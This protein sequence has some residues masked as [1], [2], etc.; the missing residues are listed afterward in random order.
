ML[1]NG[2]NTTPPLAETGLEQMNVSGEE[3]SASYPSVEPNTIESCGLTPITPVPVTAN[4]QPSPEI[5]LKFVRNAFPSGRVTLTAILSDE[6]NR[7]PEWQNKKGKTVTRTLCSEEEIISWLNRAP[8]HKLNLYFTANALAGEHRKKPEKTDIKAARFLYCD[9]DPRAG[10]DLEA[11][12]S[13]ILT[14]IRN[15][16]LPPTVVIF[17]GGGY[18]CLWLLQPEV[19]INTPEDILAVEN[20]N[21]W[22]GAKFLAAD[23]TQNI[24]RLLRLPGSVNYPD[25]GKQKKGRQAALAYVVEELTDWSRTYRLEDFLEETPPKPSIKSRIAQV[26]TLPD[27]VSL[28][29]AALESLAELEKWGISDALRDLI[30]TG[31]A[32]HHPSRSETLYAAVCGLARCGVPDA[33]ILGILLV[34]LNRR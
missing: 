23:N 12:Q 2:E 20:R 18:Q 27:L 30:A 8:A 6:A 28:E 29:P 11:E 33:V 14:E 13:R 15:L 25:A 5:A 32:P 19:P 7:P 1:H 21:R 34:A 10:E 26:T 31:K 17:S 9:C 24:D 3:T 16:E 22:L 4:P